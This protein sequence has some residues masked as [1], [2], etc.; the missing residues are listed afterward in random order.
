M[1]LLRDRVAPKVQLPRWISLNYLLGLFTLGGNMNKPKTRQKK[2]T[3]KGEPS[4][5]PLYPRDLT[6][7]YLDEPT[8]PIEVKKPINGF[9][10]RNALVRIP[11][12]RKDLDAID[13]EPNKEIKREIYNKYFGI[14][15]FS[16][17]D[18]TES[19]SFQKYEEIFPPPS[20]NSCL[21]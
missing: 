6:P 20:C 15:E 21:K 4:K 10:Y 14:S 17:K 9:D 2:R 11:E 16:P 8:K 12:V 13:K 18:F 1:T 19:R 7:N 5:K 3:P